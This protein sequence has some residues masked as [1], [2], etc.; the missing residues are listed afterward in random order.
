MPKRTDDPPR[1]PDEVVSRAIPVGV[2]IAGAW[3]WRIIGVLVLLGVLV[4][5]VILLHTVVVPV[6]VATLLSGLL[7]PLK[8]RLLRAGWPTWLAVLVTF[9]GTLVVIAGL[10]VLVVLTLRTGIGGLEQRT[11]AGY[12]NLIAAIKAS[13]FGIT[14]ADVSNAIGS[15]SSTIQK[16]SGTILA[17]ALSGASIVSDMLVGLVLS[18][19]ITLFFLIDGNGIWRWCIRLAPRRARAAVDGA[20]RAAWLSVGE[21]ARVQILVALIDAVGIGLVAFLLGLGVSLVVPIA[22]LVFLAAFIPFVGAIVTGGLAVLVAL[23]YVGPVQ[24]LIMLAGVVGVNQLESHVLQ[25]LLMGGAVR[26]HPVAVVLTVATGSLLGGIAGAVFAVP[27]VAAVNS[28][29]QFV[30]GGAWKDDAPPP[31]PP[32]PEAPSD[33]RRRRRTTRPEP[34]DVTTVG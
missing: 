26:L 28:A 20:G 25:P 18:L 4:Y 19:F 31:T 8:N 7:T 2:R 30:A 14:D 24:A 12:K 23:V 32:V 21:Y 11:V 34:Q 6:L 3:S 27:F 5:L 15:I 13:P 17:G 33:R 16:N 9:L 22:V 29:V 10:V 1:D